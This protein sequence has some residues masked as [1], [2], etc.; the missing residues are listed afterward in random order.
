MSRLT[1]FG[2]ALI[3]GDILGL[4]IAT[5][6][7]RKLTGIE[8]DFRY[9]ELNFV[10]LDWICS[11]TWIQGYYVIVHEHRRTQKRPREFSLEKI[12]DVI[13]QWLGKTCTRT[14]FNWVW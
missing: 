6:H 2:H 10:A 8:L 4:L 3:N 12:V 1:K 13:G 14:I 9:N 5:K 11:A 7:A